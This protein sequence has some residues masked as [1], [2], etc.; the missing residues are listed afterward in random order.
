M[1]PMLL[2]LCYH[3]TNT[4]NDLLPCYQC[5]SCPVTMLPKLLVPCYHVT[6]V[7][8]ATRAVPVTM[9][10]MLLMSYYHVTNAANALFPCYHCC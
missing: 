8:N 6:N 2:M 5:C 4:V 7:P 9:L 10:P 3:V 1:L